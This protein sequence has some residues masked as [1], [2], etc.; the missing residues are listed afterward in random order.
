MP[1]SKRKTAGTIVVTCRE[2]NDSLVTRRIHRFGIRHLTCKRCIIDTIWMFIDKYE[3]FG[4]IYDIAELAI[5]PIRGLTCILPPCQPFAVSKDLTHRNASHP[6]ALLPCVSNQ[7]SIS[8]TL[9]K[10][11]RLTGIIPQRPFFDV[12]PIIPMLKPGTDVKSNI[13]SKPDRTTCKSDLCRNQSIVVI[14]RIKD[15][16]Q[17]QLLGVAHAL[18][19]LRLRL[20]L[21]QRRQ[22][23][24]RQ[25]RD[26]SDH[27]QQFDE[28]KCS[29]RNRS[30]SSAGCDLKVRHDFLR[31]KQLWVTSKTS[32]K[33]TRP[34][35]I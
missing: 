30:S 25:D 15:K 17:G 18:D 32:S 13:S 12:V 33:Q 6:R 21:G 23:H 20:C 29:I 34:S 26:N 3:G 35:T 11:G 5:R 19:T 22:Q 7:A 28:R 2:I 14:T 9:I 8:G 1:I 16:R 10:R 4:R 24:R 31:L 27:N